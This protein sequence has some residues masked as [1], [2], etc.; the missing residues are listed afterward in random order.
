V[1]TATRASIVAIAPSSEAALDYSVVAPLYNEAGNVD[2]LLTELREALSNVAGSYEVVLVD[3][4]SRD[5]TR[6][7]VLRAIRNW[8][9]CRLVAFRRNQGQ[10]A[11]LLTGMR[12][13]RGAVIVT[14][15]GDGQNV[16]ADIPRVLAALGD[17]DL[18]VGARQAR[19]DSR[20]RLAMPR[21]SPM[22]SARVSSATR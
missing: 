15:D 11:A 1:N 6:A 17:A 13:A 7:A 18:V 21:V 4:G 5:E 20:V 12:Q 3:D 9:E 14:L 8:P 2:L 16:P 19:Q 10:A 22:P